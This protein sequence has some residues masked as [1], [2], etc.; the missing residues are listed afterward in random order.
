MSA[1][2]GVSPRRG[3]R[4]S[5]WPPPRAYLTLR[6]DMGSP[7]PA[8]PPRRWWGAFVVYTA[9]PPPLDVA[10]RGLVGPPASL[11]PRVASPHLTPEVEERWAPVPWLHDGLVDRP[12]WLRQRALRPS[13]RE[14][15][16]LLRL[17]TSGGSWR[18]DGTARF[19]RRASVRN[20]LR[21]R[22]YSL[23]TDPVLTFSL[24]LAGGPLIALELDRLTDRSRGD[25]N[26]VL[27]AVGVVL[28]TLGA[29]LNRTREVVSTRN[30]DA[31]ESDDLNRRF[32]A[33]ETSLREVR[34]ELGD[35]VHDL[36]LTLDDL[37]R[38][39]GRER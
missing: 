39:L 20:R 28:V 37:G 10:T 2:L 9:C 7:P 33:V 1:L 29:W 31:W 25:G 17:A 38:S 16:R 23:L 13:R 21:R 8:P 24:G 5:A 36:A 6:L 12:E 32:G 34:D 15:R 22:A 30:D 11:D 19:L 4:E 26:W 14:G 35:Q 27:L 18:T 3:S